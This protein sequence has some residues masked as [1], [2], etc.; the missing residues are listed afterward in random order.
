[1]SFFLAA[2]T[3]GT[4]L[5]Q[6][7]AGFDMAVFRFFG[8]IQNDVLN[9]IAQIFTTMGSVLYA[10]LFAVFAI[11]LC[12]FKRTRKY[13]L[14]LVFAI[15]IGTIVVNVILKPMAFRIRPYNTLQNIPEYFGW[16]QSS[17]MLAESDYSF[18]SG[19]TAVAVEIAMALCLCFASDKKWK[20]AWIPPVAALLT[21]LSRI[22]L[23]V[24]YATDVIVA[25]IIGVLAGIAGYFIGKALT[26]VINRALEK[27]AAKAGDSPGRK[28]R[29][30]FTSGQ[31]AVTCII[32][33]L[34]I[35]T[36]AFIPTITGAYSLEERCAYEGD[37]KC[38]NEAVVES[39]KYPPIDGKY[40]CKIHWNELNGK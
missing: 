9:V 23:M 26:G 33:W 20:L 31:L 28:P 18:P 4:W 34:V 35:F 15:A 16:Y 22:Y 3:L 11:V 40:Y 27:R 24:H 37:Y 38:Y 19:H 13:G 32:A 2:A 10:V 29:R 36:I 14:A 8:S 12:F 39:S 25:V 7:F 6:T 21:A 1:M 5:D 17:G 30:L